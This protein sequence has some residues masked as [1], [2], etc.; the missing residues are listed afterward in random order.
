VRIGAAENMLTPT[1]FLSY[2]WESLEHQRWVC[3]LAARLRADGINTVLDQWHAI[4]GDQ[5]P[6]FMETAVRESKF[7]LVICTPTYKLKSN[8]R[9]GGVGYEGDIM[10]AEVFTKAQRQKFIPILNLGDWQSAAP[11]WLLGTYYIDLRGEPYSEENY[12][13]LLDTLYDRREQAP[14]IGEI[15]QP[16]DLPRS[17]DEEAPRHFLIASPKKRRKVWPPNCIYIKLPT[18]ETIAF[19]I[20]EY[21]TLQ[22]LLDDLYTCYL[23]STFELAT[24]GKSWILVGMKTA[25]VVVP[26]S[27][28]L[29]SIIVPL[30][31]VEASWATLPPSHF[32]IECAV[33]LHQR[34]IEWSQSIGVVDSF[35]EAATQKYK[36]VGSFWEVR[37][38]A[39][40]SCFGLATNFNDVVNKFF[41]GDTHVFKTLP[42]L[43]NTYLEIAEIRDFIPEKHKYEAVFH[44]Q[45]FHSKINFERKI[46]KDQ[47]TR[48]DREFPT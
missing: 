6:V 32:G 11:S 18:G 2:S 13:D 31:E 41:W 12:Q 24:Y 43:L 1:V 10:T 44:N 39:P 5:L 37:S 3:E 48:L 7:V 19:K 47:S 20:L 27:W 28:L 8:N 14:P 17:F 22:E 35:M 25:R 16:N 38:I 40:N 21:F 46:L 15:Y 4:P 9:S 23:S 34:A 30:R 42:S 45:L 33:A 26:L 36:Q 29:Q